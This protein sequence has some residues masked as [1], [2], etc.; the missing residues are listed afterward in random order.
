ML[1]ATWVDIKNLFHVKKR[2]F[3]NWRETFNSIISKN[4]TRNGIQ[5]ASQKFYWSRIT[6]L[7]SI[8]EM[9]SQKFA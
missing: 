8:D 1:D 9:S 5:N 2:T 7:L 3:V 4:L 6:V